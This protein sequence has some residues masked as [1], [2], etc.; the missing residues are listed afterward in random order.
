MSNEA[1]IELGS[2]NI[3]TSDLDESRKFYSSLNLNE[4]P[5]EI[6]CFT[7][8]S[9]MIRLV[10]SCEHDLSLQM[11]PVSMDKFIERYSEL[12]LNFEYCSTSS[13]DTKLKLCDINGFPLIFTENKKLDRTT[14]ESV[15]EEFSLPTKLFGESVNFWSQI[16]YECIAKR[17]AYPRT[18]M[19]NGPVRIGL[20]DASKKPK[21]SILFKLSQETIGAV[22]K[23]G[24]P[25]MKQPENMAMTISPEGLEV[26]FS[27]RD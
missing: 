19:I 21:K 13:G 17:S 15:F 9:F 25:V 12:G 5:G 8:G 11:S 26:V 3:L 1:E 4:V 10:E 16:G 14:S 2:L 23:A 24:F 18:L 22:K 27:L 6:N 20:H 7:D